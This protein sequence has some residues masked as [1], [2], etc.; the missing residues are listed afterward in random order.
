MTTISYYIKHR[1]VGEKKSVLDG[2]ESLT[3]PIALDIMTYR[4]PLLRRVSK[5]VV[6]KVPKSPRIR[7]YMLEAKIKKTLLLYS[8]FKRRYIS[9]K[10]FS[11]LYITDARIDKPIRHLLEL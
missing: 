5:H 1:Y 2:S 6:K 4:L 3:L 8:R 11:R 9:R 10:T 7:K